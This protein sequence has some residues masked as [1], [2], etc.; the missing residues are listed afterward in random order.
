MPSPFSKLIDPWYPATAVGLERGSAAMVQLEGGRRKSFALRRAASIGLSESLIR[1]SFEE[2]NIADRAELAEALTELATGAGLLR[3]RK[4][5]VALPEA[6]ARALILT[7][8][9][10]VTSKSELEE[11]LT[12]K[13]ERGFGAPVD[14]VSIT[15]ERLAKDRQ[16]RDRYLAVG[17]RNSVLAEYESV[18]SALG[19]RAGLV[20]PRHFGEARWLTSNGKDGDSLLVTAHDEGFTAAVFRDQHP[21]ILRAVVCAPDEREDEFYRLLL[22]YRDRQTAESEGNSA[23]RIAHL[24]V[25]GP[26]FSKQRAS[27]IADE[28]LGG[29]VHALGPA[30]VGLQIPASELSFDAIAAAAG[31]ATLHWS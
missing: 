18:F 12:W 8:D 3:Q 20:L 25:V 14:E 31:L 2:P 17:V 30:D 13:M 29:H 27:E 19:W 21:L 7:P 16:G 11:I 4:W 5:S 9:S 15:R 23:E 26:G 28:T 1:P 24:L 10:Q 22:F 6:S